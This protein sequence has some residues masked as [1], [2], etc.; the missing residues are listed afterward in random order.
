MRECVK[1]WQKMYYSL[2]KDN[3]PVYEKDR[4]GKIL[5]DEDGDPIETG[6]YETLFST[7]TMFYGDIQD[8][9][10]SAVE[11][12]FGVSSADCDAILYKLRGSIPIRVMDLIWYAKEPDFKNDGSVDEKS[13]DY[14][15]KRVPPGLNEDIYL[16]DRTVK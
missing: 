12:A 1:N 14:V 13:A 5:L 16:L 8:S 3:M 9:G 4:N 11:E 6:T 15:V 10:G 7:P 2:R